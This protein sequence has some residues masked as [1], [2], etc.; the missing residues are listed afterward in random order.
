MV[1]TVCSARPSGYTCRVPVV[2]TRTL[3]APAVQCRAEVDRRG[4]LATGSATALSLVTPTADA[5]DYS[6]NSS[7]W[8]AVSLPIEDGVVLLDIAFTGSDPKHGFLTGT[9]QT[10]LETFDG[11]KTWEPRY[12][13]SVDEEGI[14]YRYNAVSFNGSEGWIVGKPGILLHTEDSGATWTR[15]PLSNKLPGAPIKVTALPGKGEAEMCTESGAIYV[16]NNTAYTWKAAVQ[17]TVDATLNRTVSS[18]I[19]GA[20]YYE[21]SFAN[22]VRSP[23]GSYIGISSR[24]N[25]YMTWSPGD[26]SWEPHNRPSKRRLQNLGWTNDERIWV[27]TRGG[28]VLFSDD[29]GVKAEN[30]GNAKI[31]SRGFGLLDIGFRT[32]TDCYACGGS[33]SLF[34]S[35]DGGKTFK[36][37]KAIDQVP[38]NLYAINFTSPTQG[39]ILGNDGILLRYLSA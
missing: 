16:T 17:E 6:V 36:R 2:G 21:G 18:G 13:E 39:F 35:T 4:L 3:R 33:G 15:I 30:F 23:S 24:G 22:I 14:N 32:D 8:E 28:D 25:F 38:G 11:G 34:K 7:E 19:S 31:G 37:L 29:D 1:S 27:T 26:A 20:S 5:A 12:I 10:L 9:K